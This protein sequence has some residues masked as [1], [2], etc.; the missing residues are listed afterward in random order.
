[1]KYYVYHLINPETDAIF[2][3]GKGTKNRMYIHEKRAKRGVKSNN[4]TA[5]FDSICDILNKNLNIKYLKA[6]ETDNEK[7]AYDFEFKEIQKFGLHN[8]TNISDTRLH[9]GISHNVKLGMANSV[10]WNNLK[11]LYKS[12]DYKEKCRIA[13]LGENNPFYGKKWNANQR[14]N[15]INANKRHKSEEHKKKIGKAH[16]GK[17]VSK[18]TRDKLSESL[19]NSKK[20][21]EKI[22]S[23]E[24]RKKQSENNSGSNNNNA[25]TYMFI[26]P[27]NTEYL[28]KGGFKIFCVD[29]Q[30]SI[31]GMQRVAHGKSSSYKGWC[32]YEVK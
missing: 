28:I 12:D 8:L 3:I 27:E 14:T 7:E 2:Y 20:F 9:Q 23:E 29:K 26:S 4:N 13:N 22:K 10:K 17:I 1:M 15:I 31:G 19:K 16:K 6:F 21:Q 11:E 24:Y 5:L 25:K 30:L 32:V 18:E